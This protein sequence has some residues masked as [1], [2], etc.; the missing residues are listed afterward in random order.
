M[1]VSAT[2]VRMSHAPTFTPQEIEQRVLNVLKCFDRIDEKKAGCA[3]CKSS[4]FI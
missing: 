4:L 3:E 2:A 1:W